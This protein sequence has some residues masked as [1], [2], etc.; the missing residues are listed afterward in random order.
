[1][2]K[3]LNLVAIS[4]NKFSYDRD[5]MEFVAEMSDFKNIENLLHQ[6]IYGDACDVGF[7]MK[8]EKTG[9]VEIFYYSNRVEKEGEAVYWVWEALNPKLDCHVKI[10]ND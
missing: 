8:S 3:T 9:N 10:F 7:A 2:A 4:S 5:T 6:R 1:M